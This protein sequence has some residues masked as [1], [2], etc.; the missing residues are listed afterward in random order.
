MKDKQICKIVED[1]LPNYVEKMTSK[2]TNTFIEEHIN[3]CKECKN[4][5]NSMNSNIIIDKVDEKE[6]DYLRKIKSKNKNKIIV[7]VILITI[8][9]FL[10]I[11]GLQFNFNKKENEIKDTYQEYIK[12]IQQQEFK[13]YIDEEEL[14]FVI[15]YDKQFK[16][17]IVLINLSKSNDK[18]LK[19]YENLSNIISQENKD[20]REMIQEVKDYTENNNGKFEEVLK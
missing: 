13:C 7:V 14:Q 11:L 17:I 3:K 4:K 12:N 10:I 8:I 2:E 20:S 9:S 16:I 19:H 5:L 1:L 18:N 6:I 15:S